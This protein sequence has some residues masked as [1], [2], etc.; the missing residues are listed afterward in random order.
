MLLTEKGSGCILCNMARQTGGIKVTGTIEGLSFYKMHGDYFVRTKSSLTARRFWKDRAFEGS[1]KSCVL[2]AKASSLTSLFYKGYPKHK[3]A[4]G[5][6][7]E[8]TGKVKLWLKEGK[9][10]EETLRLLGANYPVAQRVD[11]G[12]KKCCKAAKAFAVGKKQ[13]LFAVLH[14]K[15]VAHYQRKFTTARLYCLKE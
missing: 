7:N 6:F 5:L 13:R 9:T 10:E 14:Y 12:K 15:G 2:L 1:R 11:E 8:M 3:K 4:K